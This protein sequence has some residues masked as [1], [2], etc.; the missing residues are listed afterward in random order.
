MKINT[1][2]LHNFPKDKYLAYIHSLPSFKE[3]K[4]QSFAT[5]I[6]TLIAICLFGF[7]A[8]APT[9]GT[10]S[11]LK[12]TLN[13]DKFLADSLQ[14]KITNMSQL[15]DQYN[16]LSSQ[17][18]TLYA[19]IPKTPNTSVLS[20]KIRTLAANSRLTILQLNI[21]GVEVAS[22]KKPISV[23]TPIGIVATF[24]GSQ[25][26]FETFTKKLVNIDRII[27]LDGVGTSRIKTQEGIVYQ[28]NI[29]ATAYYRP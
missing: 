7:F 22:S 5:V 9:L 16:T 23:L 21:S 10:I 15:Q 29:R 1:N 28:L 11:Q 12:K 19:A 14:T 18:P 3:E 6:L 13:D 24:Q 4:V 8:I 26:D 17:L 27:T 25:E 20:G 2:V